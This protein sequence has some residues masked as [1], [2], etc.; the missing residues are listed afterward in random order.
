LDSRGGG[1]G[2]RRPRRAGVIVVAAG[3]GS[4]FSNAGPRKQYREL[5]GEP[6]LARA[7]RPFLA[8]PSVAQVIVVLPREDVE[9]P[10]AWLG[11][12]PVVRV[13]GGEH[14]S[15]SVR[16]GLAAVDA[17]LSI[18]LVHDGARPL[19][20][21]EL[22]DRVLRNG[23]DSATIPVVPVTD[24]VKE[25]GPDRVVVR[26]LPRERLRCVQTPQS[27]PA[28]TLRAVHARALET[29]LNASDDAGL[30]EHFGYP[31][32]VVDGDPA[33]IKV[34]TPTDLAIATALVRGL[35]ANG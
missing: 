14:R 2:D 13:A 33:N 6:I 12:M 34:T 11:E 9:D 1:A 35:P 10:P 16:N 29:G 24:T 25:V 30:F 28:D 32:R 22:I 26:T 18:V 20:S 15:D 3:S 27:F 17:T 23:S 31:V 21:R 4:R 19:V 5:G 8:H 7:L